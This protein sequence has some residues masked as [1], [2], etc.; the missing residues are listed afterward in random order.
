LQIAYFDKLDS[1]QLYLKNN[2]SNLKPP[3]LI[4]TNHQ[5]NGIGS[6]D[7][8]WLGEKGNLFFSFV[9]NKSYFSKDIPLH[10]LSIYIGW[11]IKNILSK[12][13]SKV[14]LKWPNDLYIKDKKIGGIITHIKK[15]N[16]IMGCG[17]NSKTSKNFQNLDIK[18]NDKDFLKTLINS[19]NKKYTW[20]TV[21]N[22]YSKEFHKN[23]TFYINHNNKKISLK[24]SILQNDG[25][26]KIGK[27]IIINHR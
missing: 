15:D 20:N 7:N 8:K 12:L 18:L 19:L 13:G 16:I 1:T 21:F 5:T 4:Y 9:V 14:F 10:S 2:L 6:R 22:L 27:E 3:I 11:H 24:K 23:Y 17:I 26:I 25:S